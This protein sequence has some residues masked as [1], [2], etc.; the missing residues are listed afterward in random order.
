MQL[1]N[2]LATRAQNFV[3]LGSTNATTATNVPATTAETAPATT[4]AAKTAASTS[5]IVKLAT[6]V[7]DG[8][9]AGVDLGVEAVKANLLGLVRGLT[10]FNGKSIG[11]EMPIFRPAARTAHTTRELIGTAGGLAKST[12]TGD[13]KAREKA[14]DEVLSKFFEL[15]ALDAVVNGPWAEPGS[16]HGAITGGAS[17]PRKYGRL[18][19]LSKNWTSRRPAEDMADDWKRGMKRWHATTNAVIAANSNVAELIGAYLLGIGHEIDPASFQAELSGQGH[20]VWSDSLLDLVANV[21]GLLVGFLVGTDKPEVTSRLVNQLA[22]LIPGP[23]DPFES[24]AMG[25]EDA[26]GVKRSFE[27]A[28]I[29]LFL[30]RPELDSDEKINALIDALP[31]DESNMLDKLLVL[32]W[33][34]TIETPEGNRRLTDQER[35]QLAQMIIKEAEGDEV[36]AALLEKSQSHMDTETLAGRDPWYPEDN[37]APAPDTTANL[38]K[39]LSEFDDVIKERLAPLAAGGSLRNQLTASISGP[40]AP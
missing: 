26:K 15:F 36:Y 25:V 8:T 23:P 1:R 32:H 7:R 40:D 5:R 6:A 4:G 9:I 20:G 10:P 24:E 31:K 11:T 38:R 30:D 3:P 18:V 16:Y 2:S 39:F 29:G 14:V 27:L 34:L 19:G 22:A 17:I 28:T 37:N 21:S 12:V 35:N 13:A 33:N